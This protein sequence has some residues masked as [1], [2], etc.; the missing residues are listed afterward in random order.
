MSKWIS[1]SRNLSL[2]LA[3]CCLW[4]GS[5]LLAQDISGGAG[6]SLS[7]AAGGLINMAGN[8]RQARAPQPKPQARANPGRV[9]PKPQPAAPVNNEQLEEALAMGDAASQANRPQDAERAYHLAS[10]I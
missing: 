3:A 8:K 4:G 10:K 9:P 2:A 7:A 1:S 5:S 6:P